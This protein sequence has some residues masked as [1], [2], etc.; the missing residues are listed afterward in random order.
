MENLANLDNLASLV[1]KGL[2]GQLDQMGS[3]GHKDSLGAQDHKDLL[4]LMASQDKQVVL[5]LRAHLD[6][7]V[8]QVEAVLKVLG[9][10]LACRVDQVCKEQL[11]HQAL[12]EQ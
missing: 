9:V 4:E 5:D 3:L 8:Q 1:S 7:W 12:P 11:E 6:P 10:A 2:M